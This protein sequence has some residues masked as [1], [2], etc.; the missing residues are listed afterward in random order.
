MTMT[1]LIR[2]TLNW[3]GSLTD[4]EVQIIITVGHGI[5]QADLLLE[6]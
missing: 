3:G 1:T 5:V 6:K 4:S 2:K